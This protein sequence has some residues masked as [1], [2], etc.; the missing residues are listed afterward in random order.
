[1]KKISIIAIFCLLSSGMAL[2]QA[3]IGIKAG[4]NFS[5]MDV[6]DI[7]TDSKSGFHFGAFVGIPLSENV[8]LQPEIMYS[9]YAEEFDGSEDINFNYLSIP[10]LLKFN[11]SALNLYAGPQIGILTNSDNL[12]DGLADAT[13]KDS[14]KKQ[15]W[16]VVLGAGID[17]PA[18]LE[19]GGRYVYGVNDISDVPGLGSAKNRLWQLYL[20]LTLFGER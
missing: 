8:A 17:L 2:A 7:S 6:E 9:T 5:N 13:N 12:S 11:V 15:D 1:M 3:G 10:I 4:A 14:W 19:V 16:S 18:N 20:A